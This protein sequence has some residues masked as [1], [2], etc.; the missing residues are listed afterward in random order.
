MVST[1]IRVSKEF[2][3]EIEKKRRSGESFE[4]AVLNSDMNKLDKKLKK[5]FDAQEMRRKIKFKKWTM[6]KR[7]RKKKL[8][9]KKEER[10]YYMF[11]PSYLSYLNRDG[12]R[13]EKEC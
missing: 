12:R 4:R 7:K 9:P 8:N 3:R 6:G 1:H 10:G 11:N 13:M 2:K 5:I